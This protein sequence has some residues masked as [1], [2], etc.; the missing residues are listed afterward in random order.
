MDLPFFPGH[1]TATK[2]VQSFARRPDLPS[3]SWGKVL[4][5][6]LHFD[7]VMVWTLPSFFFVLS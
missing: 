2:A 5:V 7:L 4:P 1:L 6:G 3:L